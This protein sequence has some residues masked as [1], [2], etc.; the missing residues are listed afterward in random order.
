MKKNVLFLAF[1]IILGTSCSS[2]PTGE[3]LNVTGNDTFQAK[4]SGPE[5]RIG[6]RVKLVKVEFDPNGYE[7]QLGKKIV[8]GEGRVS[9][10]L[11]K[12]LYEIKTETAQYIPTDA[13]IEKL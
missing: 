8:I 12:G 2:R 1:I 3:V 5:L 10:I 7:G 9:T 11:N 6:D 13:F 4:Y